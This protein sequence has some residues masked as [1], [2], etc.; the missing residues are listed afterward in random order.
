MFNHLNYADDCVLLAP[1]SAALQSLISI[2]EEF[3]NDNEMIY[4][5]KKTM[6]MTFYPKSFDRGFRVQQPL[7]LD[8][9]ILKWSSQ[10]KYLWDFY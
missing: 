9:V 5:T 2:C 7:F 8:N 6:C 1:S 10:H 3:A 4:N